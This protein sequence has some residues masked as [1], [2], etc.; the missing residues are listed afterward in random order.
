MARRKRN[1]V[2]FGCETE[3]AH[4]SL[5]LVAHGVSH[6]IDGGSDPVADKLTLGREMFSDLGS[7]CPQ[8]LLHLAPYH[9]AQMLDAF[10]T[11][12]VNE[13]LDDRRDLVGRLP[14]LLNQIGAELT[15]VV[16][17]LFAG[18]EQSFH[19]EVL[20]HRLVSFLGCHTSDRSE[21][22]IGSGI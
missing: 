3:R 17:D 10:P 2:V 6:V 9:L 13:V 12:R 7:E 14:P 4:L 19:V 5:Y 15:A 20:G 8:R 22:V 16:G 18:R 1:K 11:D 21:K